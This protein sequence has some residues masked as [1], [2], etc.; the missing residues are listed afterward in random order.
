VVVLSHNELTAQTKIQS[1]GTVVLGHADQ[2][3]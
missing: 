3:V 2:A 1:L